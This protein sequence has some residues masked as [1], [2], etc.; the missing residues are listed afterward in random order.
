MNK[1]ALLLDTNVWIDLELEGANSGEVAALFLAAARR[2]ARL[3]IASH[4]LKDVFAIVERR[5]KHA[6][7]DDDT[8]T[9]PEAL[10]RVAR[11]IAWGVV[12]HILEQAEVV[13][14]DYSDAWLALKGRPLHD[15]YEDN[16]VVA[17]AKRM[18]ADLLVTSDLRLLKH[19]PVA[20]LSVIDA[21]RWLEGNAAGNGPLS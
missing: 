18:E 5:I 7:R 9:D 4:S 11:S 1:P 19:A 10:G 13:G 15:F 16:L 21:R 17:A 12:E 20:T 3:G 8:A 2:D 6:A 14:A